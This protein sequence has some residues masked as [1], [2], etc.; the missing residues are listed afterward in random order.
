MVPIYSK[1]EKT[2]Y[3]LWMP[4]VHLELYFKYKKQLVL[5]I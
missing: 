5:M 1:E 3:A 2:A 4:P